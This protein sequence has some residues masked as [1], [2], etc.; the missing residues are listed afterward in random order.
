MRP[1]CRC[2]AGD[3]Q[4][5]HFC[6]GE[7]GTFLLCVYTEVAAIV[8]TA[9]CDHTGGCQEIPFGHQVPARRWVVSVGALETGAI[10][11]VVP[12]V[13]H[14]AQDPG[15]KLNAISHRHDIGMLSHLRFARQRMQPAENHDG[16]A[17]A[18]PTRQ[19]VSS[20]GKGEVHRDPHDLR[21]RV[22]RRRALEQ[23]LIPVPEPPTVRGSPRDAG[24]G[25]CRGQYVFAETGV[26]V[27]AVERIDQQP[28]IPL[29]GT[30]GR[31]RIQI[32]WTGK[33]PRQRPATF[34]RSLHVAVCNG[35]ED[36]PT[37]PKRRSRRSNSSSA[38]SRSR[39]LKSGHSRSLKTNSA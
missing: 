7:K 22:Q 2:S 20:I 26:F 5:G 11:S 35:L 37:D 24:Q 36:C 19:F 29:H 33:F 31:V 27:L 13:S 34:R 3:G 30:R 32:G 8:T 9:S 16:A 18:E 1:R 4:R 21:E 23:V 15:P 6:F 12:A 28:V 39:S 17:R 25:E 14:I 38:A 10:N